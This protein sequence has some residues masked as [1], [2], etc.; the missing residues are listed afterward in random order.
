MARRSKIIAVVSLAAILAMVIGFVAVDRSI[1]ASLQ[2]RRGP[3]HRFPLKSGEA[4][5]TDSYGTELARQAMILDGYSTA[6]WQPVEDRRS[7]AP[8]GQK[9][10]YIAR[11]LDDPLRGTITFQATDPHAPERYRY[12]V[13]EMTKNEVSAQ[14]DKGK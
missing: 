13:L 7:T 4:F 8:D 9:D 11:N 10:I 6:Q 12:V 5:L 1:N 2:A 3:V 14:V